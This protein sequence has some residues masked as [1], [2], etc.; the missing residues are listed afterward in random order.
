VSERHSVHAR[1]YPEVDT[2]PGFEPSL[3]PLCGS[4]DCDLCLVPPEPRPTTRVGRWLLHPGGAVERLS[5]AA[6][7]LHALGLRTTAKRAR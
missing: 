2:A 6:W 3:V 1:H 7:A 4:C 5:L